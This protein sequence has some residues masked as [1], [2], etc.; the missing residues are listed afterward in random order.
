MKTFLAILVFVS[1]MLSANLFAQSGNA[2]VSGTVADASGALLPGV[3]MTA[4]N[5]QTG[6]VSNVLSNE[7]GTYNFAS[8]QPGIY[9]V[10]A[11]LP[12][13][14]IQTYT[15]VQLGTSQQV[16]LNFTLQVST[17]AQAVEVTVA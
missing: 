13:F 8:L 14:Q 12:G 16:R 15:D 10:T 6:V 9:K 7:A 4:T 2:T 5:T 1:V 17:V 11:E 3:M